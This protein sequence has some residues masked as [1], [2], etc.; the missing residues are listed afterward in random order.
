ML[1]DRYLPRIEF[2]SYEDF[3][4]NYKVNAPEDFN[5]AYDIVDEWAKQDIN[6]KALVW[7]DDNNEEVTLTFEDIRKMSN[8]AANYFKSKGLKKGS[9]VLLILRQRWE[10]WVIVTAL[11]KLGVIFIP[12]TLQL[13]KKD[14]AYRANAAG[15]EMIV[16]INDSYVR[17]RRLCP[18]CP[19]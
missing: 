19:A 5:F 18:K 11:M 6:K 12:A 14:I 4:Q 2:D 1:L 9:V 15:V 8:K 3:K 10:Y 17:L 16:C 13:T 7:C